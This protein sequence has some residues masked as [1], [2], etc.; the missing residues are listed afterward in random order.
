MAQI[1]LRHFKY[2][3]IK[4][5]KYTGVNE[6]VGA[7]KS[8]PS[9]NVAEA[10]LY[11]DDTV[12]E[13]ASEVTKGSLSLTVADDDDTIF[14]PLLGHTT[15]EDGEVLKSSDD[16]PPYVGF[17]RVLVK[18]VNGV[19]KYKAE[20]FLKV[21]FKPFANEGDTKGESIEFKTPTVEG[22]IYVVPTVVNGVEKPLYERHQTFDTDEEAQAY[23]DELMKAP[24][25]SPTE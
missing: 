6:M 8:T 12:V 9:L 19:R 2:S 20:F 24:T 23:L 25:T 16:T 10:E 13:S 14:A 3:P 22:T 18:M 17:G 7:I 4:D 11:A 15:T 1:G 21:K 5:G